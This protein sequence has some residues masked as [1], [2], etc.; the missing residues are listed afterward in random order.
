M[1]CSLFGF[2]GNPLDM[3][4][5]PDF[6][7]L[8]QAHQDTLAGLIFR[9]RERRGIIAIMGEVGTGKSTLLHALRSRLDDRTSLAYICITGVT[10]DEML[11]LVLVHL[12]LVRSD[13][14]LIKAE[15]L[16]RLHEF[17]LRKLSTGGNV[18]LLVDEAQ[19]LNR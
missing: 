16:H 1:Y 7:Y 18:V 2:S 6:S 13:E 4:P 11:A 17:S 5:D 9:I 19:N 15:R 12:K 8:S 10:F 3:S 14:P